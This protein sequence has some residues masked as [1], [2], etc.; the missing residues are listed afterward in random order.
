MKKTILLVSVFA[1]FSCE[2]ENVSSIDV[3]VL[4]K[5]IE[6]SEKVIYNYDSSNNP[7]FIQSETGFEQTLE[8]SY[9]NGLIETLEYYNEFDDRIEIINITTNTD[10]EFYATL[11]GTIPSSSTT[12]TYDIRYTFNGQ[13]IKSIELLGLEN[14]D[15]LNEFYHDDEGRLTRIDYYQ[16]NVLSSISIVELWDT[17]EKPMTYKALTYR[18]FG[19]WDWFPQHYTTTKNVLNYTTESFINGNSYN[20][21]LS[22]IYNDNGN[23]LQIEED[24]FGS[25]RIVTL[26]YVEAN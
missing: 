12:Y 2:T 5:S 13:L 8:Y 14:Q 3:D 21:G 16:N 23:V 26:D 20:N 15:F 25:N 18:Q 24:Y 9:S 6:I 4:L 7:V 19:F 10:T 11:T 22:Y 1:F 17:N